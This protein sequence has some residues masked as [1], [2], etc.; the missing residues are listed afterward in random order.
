MDS[1]RLFRYTFA[2]CGLILLIGSAVVVVGLAPL[3]ARQ[4]TPWRLVWPLWT[5]ALATV[6]EVAVLIGTP[7]GV[8]LGI[9]SQSNGD[10]S[11]DSPVLVARAFWKTAFFLA[12]WL[13]ITATLG[14]MANVHFGAPGNTVRRVIRSA[15]EEC[16]A[17]P[18]RAS[19]A[20][21]LL[22]ARWVCSPERPSMLVGELTRGGIRATY[23][24]RG[25][26]LS[27][28]LVSIGLSNLELSVNAPRGMPT[29]RLFV[30][31]A[32]MRG[33]WPWARQTRPSGI[34][35]AIFVSVVAVMVSAL[36]LGM[37]LRYRAPRLSAIAVATVGAVSSW[38]TLRSVDLHQRWGVASW[39]I[40]PAA[41]ALSMIVVRW[42]LRSERIIW[43]GNKVALGWASW[44]A[45]LRRW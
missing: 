26:Q 35:R 20:V 30:E 14:A 6:L 16:E 5:A 36:A 40:V 23:A 25:I 22:G 1:P 24:T 21:P 41:A 11:A 8:A 4:T 17:R 33:A 27:E 18:S 7:L 39:V 15:R 42:L 9:S 43:T 44:R 37:C 31:K 2:T 38:Y 32:N 29:M 19:V 10:K 12:L 34:A 28:D 3:G 13:A 45:A